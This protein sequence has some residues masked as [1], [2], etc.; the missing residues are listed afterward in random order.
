MT[1]FSERMN[2]AISTAQLGEREEALHIFEEIVA[3]APANVQAWLWISEL[4]RSLEEQ[5]RAL[6]Q[7]M[8][9]ANEGKEIQQDLQTQLVELRGMMGRSAP[10][11]QYNTL[12]PRE[13]S[14]T[15]KSDPL[16]EDKFQQADR[17]AILGKHEEAIGILRDMEE[18]NLANE[19]VW[20]LWSELESNLSEKTRLLTKVL[21]ANPNNE[22]A[23]RRLQNLRLMMGNPL[24]VGQHLEENG[25]FDQAVDL[26]QSIVTHSKSA[27][28]RIE[29]NRRI[30]NIETLKHANQAQAVHPN[31]NLLRL[32]A[33]PVLLF[34]ILVFIQSGLNLLQLPALAI[35]GLL[36]TI[37]G[38]LIIS[39][40]EMRPI[41]P[42]W[43]VW[44]GKPGTESE[45]KI[46]KSAR[47]LGWGLIIIPYALFLVSA[48]ARFGILQ[49]SLNLFE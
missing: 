22:E 44:F 7:A 8:R 2:L 36:S 23:A 24:Q 48:G 28:E 43:I 18:H 47:I 46:R 40:I 16:T 25:S 10:A 33:G 29:A 49:S 4:T 1:Q 5:T 37:A 12:F 6:D 39:A 41:H 14:E 9:Y 42:Q 15:T 31:L 38:S 35:P 45:L 17:L 11:G 21:N 20:L 3:E 19:R 27:A 34:L 30:S 32:A 13:K 26:Y